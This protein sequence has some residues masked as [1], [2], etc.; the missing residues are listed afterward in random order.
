[1]PAV[2]ICRHHG[3][4]ETTPDM[5]DRTVR[6]EDEETVRRYLR[7][8]LPA[9]DGPLLR[10]RVCMYTN[11]PDEHFLLGTPVRAPRV[12]LLGGFSG[13]GYKFASVVGE[14]A[15]DLVEKETSAFDLGMFAPERFE[16]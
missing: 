9:A 5:V 16:S 8:H 14:V 4:A 11:T 2:K 6:P 15:A 12:V 1:V 3:G 10:S 13:H 7:A